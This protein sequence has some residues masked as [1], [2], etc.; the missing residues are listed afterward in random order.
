MPEGPPH[1]EAQSWWGRRPLATDVYTAALDRTRQIYERFDHVCVSFSGGKDSTAVLNVTLAVAHELDQLPVHVIFF[2]EEAISYQTEAYVRRCAQRDDIE[3]DWYCLPVLHR[4][5]CSED[6]PMWWPWAPEAKARWVRPLPPEAIT[7]LDGFP[8]KPPEARPS[9]PSAAEYLV[10]PYERFG[11]TAMVMGIRADESLTRRRAVSN[12]REDNWLIPTRPGYT[13]AYPVYDWSTED[14]WTAPG[15]LGWDYNDSYDRMEMA[16]ISHHAQRLAPPFGE[17]PIRDL[18][19]WHQAFPDIWD[20]LCYRVPGAQAAARYSTSGLYASFSGRVEKPMELTWEE[21]IAARIAEQPAEIRATIAAKV[22]G[23]IRRHW[24]KAGEP[25]AGRAIHPASGMSWVWIYGI[26]DKGDLKDR[27]SAA[28]RMAKDQSEW[29]ELLAL[30]RAE[31]ED[32][33]H[34]DYTAE[35]TR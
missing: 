1:K 10:C 4:N 35:A 3:L 9:L 16:G 7:K 11:H 13:K 34:A 31:M 25:L 33:D 12:R 30:Y 27:R 15:S 5:A 2:D 20:K 6:E 23:L 19:V 28:V 29:N 8:M 22:Q 24:K 32:A 17:E 18:W 26:A 21:F 14:V